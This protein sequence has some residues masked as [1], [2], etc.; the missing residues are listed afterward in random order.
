MENSVAPVAALRGVSK[1]FGAVTAVESFDLE[2]FPNQIV[3]LVGDNGAGKSTLIKTIAGIHQP[4]AGHIE[5]RGQKVT[6]RGPKD[7]RAAGIEV[8]YQDL[9]LAVDQPVYMNLFLGREV[10]HGPLRTLHRRE[11]SRLTKQLVDDLDVRIPSVSAPLSTLSGGQRQAVAICRA[12][13]W[14]SSI[15][16]LD[17]PTAALGVAETKK[18]EELILRL[19]ERGAAILLVSHNMDQVFRLADRVAV[20][21]RG[22]QA[23]VLPLAETTRNHLVS[24]ITGVAE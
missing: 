21:R 22:K 12:T 20:L 8:V 14:A 16:L 17:E 18:V 19:K 1:I 7:A 10:T 5:L 13:H 23:D 6:L 11:M 9:A 2:L 24:M 15:V 3:A 4:T